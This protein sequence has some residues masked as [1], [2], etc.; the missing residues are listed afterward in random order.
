MTTEMIFSI[1]SFYPTIILCFVLLWFARVGRDFNKSIVNYF[2]ITLWCIIL[3]SIFDIGELLYSP[4]NGVYT[5]NFMRVLFSVLGYC[6]RPLIAYL[7]LLLVTKNDSE[8]K[9]MLLSVPLVIN[10]LI[11]MLAF[12]T[13]AIFYFDEENAFHRGSIVG[14][15]PFVVSLLYVFFVILTTLIRVGI[16]DRLENGVLLF[17]CINS[18]LSTIIA[19]NYT[20][21]SI[22]TVSAVISVGIYYMYLHSTQNNLDQLTHAYLRRK[23]F[24]DVEAR[25]QDISAIISIDLNGLKQ[26]N[27]EFGHLVG[28]NELLKLSNTILAYITSKTHL[29]RMGGDEFSIICFKMSEDDV[30]NLI[31]RIKDGLIE[32]RCSAAI[33]YAMYNPKTSIEETMRLADSKMYENKNKMKNRDK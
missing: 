29:Y 15:L 28:D 10:T 8:K 1:S 30:Q 7:I 12:F 21:D 27:D 26:I 3:L 17:V 18:I 14:Y 33:G 9:R 16:R 22:V 31:H 19:T 2:S 25:K 13:D 32:T 20:N 4:S 5:K 24:I 23:F 6:F 11:M